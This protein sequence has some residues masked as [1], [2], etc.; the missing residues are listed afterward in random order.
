MAE[1]QLAILVG[2][3]GSRSADDARLRLPTSP[4]A[5]AGYPVRRSLAALSMRYVKAI[6]PL[7]RAQM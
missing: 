4:P 7:S 2:A 6:S 1:P 3:N 5:K